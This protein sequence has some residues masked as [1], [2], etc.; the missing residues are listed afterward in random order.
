[1][2]EALPWR[3]R[4]ARREKERK[5]EAADLFLSTPRMG[6]EEKKLSRSK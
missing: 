2:T 6:A 4:E 5:S 3:C 1:L